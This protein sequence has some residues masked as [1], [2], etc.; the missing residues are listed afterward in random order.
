MYHQRTSAPRLSSINSRWLKQKNENGREKEKYEVKKKDI[1]RKQEREKEYREGEKRV[2]KKKKMKRKK[3]KIE[4]RY[5]KVSF[6]TG[7][8]FIAKQ[9]AYRL[10][11]RKEMRGVFQ[12]APHRRR[13]THTHTYTSRRLFQYILINTSDSYI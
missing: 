13:P 12:I 2:K 3:K 10:E 11:N 1:K 9:V 8:L 4:T 5:S 7:L 6:D